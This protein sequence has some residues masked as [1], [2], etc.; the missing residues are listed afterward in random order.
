MTAADA[1]G[2]L[3]R[4][5]VARPREFPAIRLLAGGDQSWLWAKLSQQLT[6][7]DAC[8]RQPVGIAY[9]L[10]FASSER[11]MCTPQTPTP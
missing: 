9:E 11:R 6:V 3:V 7:A 10:P 1:P 4:A 5:S 2:S 8:F